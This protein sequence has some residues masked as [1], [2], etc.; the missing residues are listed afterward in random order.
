MLEGKIARRC[1]LVL[2][3]NS[4]QVVCDLLRLHKGTKVIRDE[5]KGAGSVCGIATACVC[6]AGAWCS[7]D[8]PSVTSRSPWML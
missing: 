8:Q 1:A 4:P 3:R 5:W 7:D 2:L 6:G